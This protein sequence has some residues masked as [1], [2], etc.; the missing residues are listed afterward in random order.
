MESLTSRATSLIEA[1]TNTNQLQMS[2]KF[3][4]FN[5][6]YD[7]FVLCK[8]FRTIR[9]RKHVHF[10]QKIDNPLIQHNH[11]TRARVNNKLAIPRYSKSK[12]QNALIFC[13]IKLWNTTPDDILVLNNQPTWLGFKNI[14]N[15]LY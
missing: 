9:K 2:Y 8:T 12:C 7:Y 10:T 3:I 5:G 13:G 11:E 1:H 4:Q 15:V 6:V 14:S